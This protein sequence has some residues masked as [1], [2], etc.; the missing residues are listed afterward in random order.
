MTTAGQVVSRRTESKLHFDAGK[1]PKRYSLPSSL[2]TAE[3]E[4]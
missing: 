2:R 4:L 3:E 1:G